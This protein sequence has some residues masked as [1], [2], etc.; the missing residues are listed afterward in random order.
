[1]I[2][3]ILLAVSEISAAIVQYIY[4]KNKGISGI[5]AAIVKVLQKLD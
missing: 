3:T 4:P 5:I 2:M 1:M